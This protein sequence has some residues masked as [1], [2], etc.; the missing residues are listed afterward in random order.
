M[1]DELKSLADAAKIAGENL[2]YS[3]EQT[4]KLVDEMKKLDSTSAMKNLA[5]D[6]KD[7]TEKAA[8]FHATLTPIKDT[9]EGMRLSAEK[10]TAGLGGLL[11]ALYNTTDSAK[12]A[13]EQFA[14]A[15]SNTNFGKLIGGIDEVTK[16]SKEFRG[17][18]IR[19]GSEFGLGFE[20]ARGTYQN[21]AAAI[22]MANNATYASRE[23]VEQQALGLSKMGI[24]LEEMSRTL[25]VGGE[26]QNLLTEGFRLAQDTGL[27]E[28]KVFDIMATA[29]RKM[30][31]S[32]EDAN[33][34]ILA[35]Q[36]LAK[37][38]GLPIS[39]LSGKIFGLAEQY[40]RFG[41][42]VESISPI[43]R[44]FT[45]VLGDG[46]KGLAIDDTMKLVSGLASQVNTTNAAFMAMQSGMARPGAGVAGAMLDFEDAMAEPEKAM[47]MLSASLGNISGGKILTM[48]DARQ[49]EANATQFKLQRDMLSQLTGINDPQQTKTLLALLSAQQSGKA[50][51]SEENKTLSEAMK[52]GANK[53]EEQR[54][55]A[56]KIGKAQVGL[57]AQI[58]YSMSNAATNL[59]TPRTESAI[60]GGAA[61]KAGGFATTAEEFM[62]GAID[63][64]IAAAES[65]FSKNAPDTV[66]NATTAVGNYIDENAAS[67]TENP[68]TRV[69]GFGGEAAMIVGGIQPA[70]P[71]PT[72]PGGTP[73]TGAPAPTVSTQQTSAPG[74]KEMT[75]VVVTFRGTD[76]LTKAIAQAAAQAYNKTL[77]GNG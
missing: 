45:S 60:I 47:K 65:F 70:M 35:L 19:I 28:A 75:H 72:F 34:P 71:T 74:E 46:F 38:T 33:R 39:D 41:V 40:S 51:T 20:E 61:R 69:P 73:A 23:A 44:R 6:T 14:S 21:Y 32:I 2:G 11:A 12:D 54:S 15:W 10:V 63:K 77:H 48:E 64:G 36:S 5:K 25:V 18:A 57:L 1:A 22:L 24:S 3:R 13:G 16:M 9:I 76:D 52:S 17:E 53:Q 43:L 67:I 30:G 50:L 29:S 8:A 58:A 49:S 62:S 31:L 27:A 66:K 37:S 26:N 56:E 59:L 68:R 4:T 42:S 7:A 55:L